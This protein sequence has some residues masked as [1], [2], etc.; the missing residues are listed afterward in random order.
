M[1]FLPV[2][3]DLRQGL[4]VL[5]GSGAHAVAKLRMLRAGGARVCWYRRGA[6][7]I[8]GSA[9][10]SVEIVSDFRVA[11]VSLEDASAVIT[12][13]AS[14]HDELIAARARALRLPVNVR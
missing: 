9:D 6:D 11:D 3:L 8:D 7:S 1:R 14:P 10:P 4:V 2:F 13:A 12:A 5:V